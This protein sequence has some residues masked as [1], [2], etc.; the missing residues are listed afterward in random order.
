MATD[1]RS[2]RLQHGHAWTTR[3][4]SQLFLAGEDHPT[5]TADPSFPPTPPSP[6]ATPSTTAATVPP[7]VAAGVDAALGANKAEET[8]DGE[9]DDKERDTVKAAEKVD[10]TA[11]MFAVARAAMDRANEAPLPAPKA[12]PTHVP[13]PW[14]GR[15]RNRQAHFFSGIPP[16]AAA[17]LKSCRHAINMVR[18]VDAAWA[19][20]L[21]ARRVECIKERDGSRQ[22]DKLLLAKPPC[23]QRPVRVARVKRDL[24]SYCLRPTATPRLSSPAH[25]PRGPPPGCGG[26]HRPSRA[27]TARTP[28]LG[29]P[30]TMAP[31]RVSLWGSLPRP[32]YLVPPWPP[33]VAPSLVNGLH[34][35]TA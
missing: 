3:H 8:E 11:S 30:S 4:V 6:D 7:P 22:E 32:S 15:N 17:N 14:S 16:G 24:H 19:R 10:A 21:Y 26:E 25:M 5:P 12:A 1:K 33:V 2:A 20:K 13:G 28:L 27:R 9:E 34:Y 18:P 31:P 23:T 29:A 35:V